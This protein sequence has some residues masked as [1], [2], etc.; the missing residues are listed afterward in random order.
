MKSV[1]WSGGEKQNK[2][3]NLSLMDVVE[4]RQD[5]TPVGLGEDEHAGQGKSKASVNI[6]GVKMKGSI[7]AGAAKTLAESR[8]FT[9][10]DT[11]LCF[12]FINDEGERVLSLVC[13]N[14]NR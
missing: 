1:Y 4:I 11:E 8:G 10:K 12:S 2:N 14:K 3:K 13:P 7:V 5:L 6:K 9:P